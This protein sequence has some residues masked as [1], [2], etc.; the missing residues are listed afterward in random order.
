M[1][2]DSFWATNIGIKFMSGVYAGTYFCLCHSTILHSG[3]E[4]SLWLGQNKNSCVFRLLNLPYFLALTPK[5]VTTKAK[6]W[7]YLGQIR[8]PRYKIYV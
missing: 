8:V 1:C 7:K 3:L 2:I 5:F 6:V 4:E